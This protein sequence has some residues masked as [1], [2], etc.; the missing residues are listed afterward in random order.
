[1]N[2]TK[3]PAKSG[4]GS[5]LFGF[6]AL[7]ALFGA[8][9]L[10]GHEV[11]RASTDA[12]IAPIILSPDNDIVVASKLKASELT[13]E[14]AKTAA[15]IEAVDLELEAGEKGIARLRALVIT[16]DQAL[17]FTSA[18]NA[19]QVA[20]GSTELR[21]LAEQRTFLKEMFE[22]QQK[23][24]ATARANAE[25]GLVSKTDV[26][27]EV[28]TESQLSLA[29]VENQRARH[30]TQLALSQAVLVQ[31]SLAG[32][33]GPLPEMT[34]R[35]DQLVR[36]ELELLR[37]DAE[38]RTKRTERKVLVEKLA[39]IDEM[40]AQLKSRPV[41][42]AA[43]KSMDVAFVPYT[44]IGGFREGATVYDCVWGLV[45]CKPVGSVSEMVPG[46]VVLPDPWGNQARGQ[47]VVLTLNEHEAAKSKTL[48]VRTG[49]GLRI[50]RTKP[51]TETISLR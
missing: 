31:R 50:D 47:F 17:A 3:S 2:E 12:F 43:E 11:Y 13:V 38:Q 49:A 14:R 42:R 40:A 15:Q 46:E 27:R 36:V 9:A 51:S 16:A 20:A 41:F 26:A 4:I 7:A 35:E 33:G 1:M 30:S 8:L 37:L 6:T 19:R 25:A 21:L 5:R 39:K 29:L 45:S 32:N 48:R 23:L 18:V 34:V 10:G 28:Q 44:Q 22:R 24:A